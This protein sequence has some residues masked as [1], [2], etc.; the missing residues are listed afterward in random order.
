MLIIEA[1]KLEKLRQPLIK[2]LAAALGMASGQTALSAFI[3][4]ADSQISA[5]LTVIREQF[6]GITDELAQL[7]KLNERLIQQSLDY[8]SYNINVLSQTMAESTYVP[9]GQ[10][11]EDRNRR[12]ILDTKA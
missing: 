11:G 5:K 10:N 2:E 9:K 12:S 3:N 4:H 7:N 8:I 1:G 6:T